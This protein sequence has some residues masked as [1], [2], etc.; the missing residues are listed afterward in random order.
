MPGGQLN[1]SLVADGRMPEPRPSIP[2]SGF[3]TRPEMGIPPKNHGLQP[4]DAS[5]HLR[6]ANFRLIVVVNEDGIPAR[7]RFDLLSVQGVV[8]VIAGIAAETPR[9]KIAPNDR[10]V[11][12]RRGAGVFHCRVVHD[13][14]V[15]NRAVKPILDPSRN[16][17]QRAS[18]RRF[19]ACIARKTKASC[20]HRWQSLEISA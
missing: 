3:R 1:E 17:R 2:D 8:A 12:A 6:N 15:S 20:A 14:F 11:C 10:Y 7:K 18:S 9:I 19:R 4:C 16:C 13:G 5:E